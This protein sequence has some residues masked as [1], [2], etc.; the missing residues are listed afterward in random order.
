MNQVIKPSFLIAVLL[1]IAPTILF[2]A[3]IVSLSGCS[4]QDSEKD[5]E[6]VYYDLRGFIE[7]QIVYM[8][9]KRPEVTKTTFLNGESETSKT[10]DINWKKELELFL[11]ADLN[12]PSYKRSY[13]IV[14]KDSSWYEYTLK[15]SANLPVRYLKI[16]TGKNLNQPVYV[17]A[18]I[19]VEN[20]IYKSEKEIELTCAYR[21]NLFE[22]SAYSVK[23]YQKLIFLEEKSFRIDSK[24]GL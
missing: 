16:T 9:E 11:Q 6:K 12:K 23:G 5:G 14:R 24:I 8:T 4:D 15:P 18:L 1:K 19:R 20:K 7:N 22:L 2:L 3:V 21:N 17:K 10:K 13:N